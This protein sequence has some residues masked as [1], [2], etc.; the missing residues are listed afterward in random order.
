[1]KRKN[2]SDELIKVWTVCPND[3]EYST[4]HFDTKESAEGWA[5]TYKAGASVFLNELPRR[6]VE[7]KGLQTARRGYGI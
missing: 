6:V 2:K 1:M 7:A 4:Q 5:K 3:M